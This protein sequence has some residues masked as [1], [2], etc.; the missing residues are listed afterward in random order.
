MNNSENSGILP[1]AGVV[2]LILGV[3]IGLG[4]IIS[5]INGSQ[6]SSGNPQ[7]NLPVLSSSFI[8]YGI[9]IVLVFLG[10]LLV[11]LGRG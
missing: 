1:L 11:F 2:L 5:Q 7:N 9:A 4:T 3:V 6:D 8:W 10:I